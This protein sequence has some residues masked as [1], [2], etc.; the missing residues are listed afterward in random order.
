MSELEE[1]T[2]VVVAGGRM[3]YLSGNIL[4][5]SLPLSSITAYTQLP[6]YS[7]ATNSGN[8]QTFGI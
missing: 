7:Q 8:R 6:L 1:G 2:V 3:K 4:L 5:V